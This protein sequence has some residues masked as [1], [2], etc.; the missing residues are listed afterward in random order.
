S[1]FITLQLIY[2]TVV[3]ILL[4][5]VKGGVFNGIMEKCKTVGR[6]LARV[7]GI[8]KDTNG[9]FKNDG[10]MEELRWIANHPNGFYKMDDKERTDYKLKTLKKYNTCTIIRPP[11]FDKINT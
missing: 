9:N 6:S 11:S 1:I 8:L 5:D 7:L 4:V 2:M 3:S 10:P